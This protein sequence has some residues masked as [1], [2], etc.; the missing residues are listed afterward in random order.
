[1]RYRISLI[2]PLAA[3]VIFILHHRDFMSFGSGDLYLNSA[4]SLMAVAS[5]TLSQVTSLTAVYA[6]SSTASV[7]CSKQGGD[8]KN[9]VNVNDDAR[10]SVVQTISGIIA[11]PSSPISCK[12]T[13]GTSEW[14]FS[15][16]GSY[17]PSVAATS[18]GLSSMITIDPCQ[19]ECTRRQTAD[20]ITLL[21]VD[22]ILPLI[23]T[24]IYI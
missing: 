17:L 16:C 8:V 10:A 18:A 3:C 7:S 19:A 12:N 6:D 23:H 9:G 20:G 14:T 13:S 1:V 15:K 11:L 4:S 5:I 2:F 22:I 21:I 24:H